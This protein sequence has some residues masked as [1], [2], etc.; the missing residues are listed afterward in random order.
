MAS[1][2]LRTIPFL[3]L[4]LCQL[5]DVSHSLSQTQATLGDS[6][7]EITSSGELHVPLMRREKRTENSV[8]ALA[9]IQAHDAS[10][11]VQS[12]ISSLLAKGGSSATAQGAQTPNITNDI[13]DTSALL[14]LP[15][16][17]VAFYS[18]Y[19]KRFLR[20]RPD[21]GVDASATLETI[22]DLP[23]A[24]GWER[25]TVV[26]ASNGQLA[27]HN[28]AHNRFLRMRADGIVEASLPKGP[29]ELPTDWKFERFAEVQGG[30][31]SLAIFSVANSR[32]VR[33]RPDGIIDASALRLADSLPADWTWERFTVQRVRPAVLRTQTPFSNAS[34]FLKVA[35]E[36]RSTAEEL[37]RSA[38]K[39]RLV[40]AKVLQAKKAQL[41][42]IRRARAII[43]NQTKPQ[44]VNTSNNESKILQDVQDTADEIRAAAAGTK[45]LAEEAAAEQ[46]RQG[47]R[48]IRR[49]IRHR[50][51]NVSKSSRRR[52]LPK[53]TGIQTCEDRNLTESQCKAI[54]CCTYD[55][56][57]KTCFSAV[58]TFMCKSQRTKKRL[59]GVEV[60]EGKNIDAVLCAS[61]PCCRFNYEQLECK[62]RIGTRRC[63]F[64]NPQS[65][66]AAEVM[67]ASD[68]N[69][70]NT[71]QTAGNASAPR[72]PRSPKDA[73]QFR[74]SGGRKQDQKTDLLNPKWTAADQRAVDKAVEAA[75]DSEAEA[76]R[77]GRQQEPPMSAG[78]IAVIVIICIVL[79][80][81]LGGFIWWYLHDRPKEGV[82]PLVE[83]DD[84]TVNLVSDDQ[85]TFETYESPPTDS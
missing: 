8:P 23:G 58:G 32:F 75:T 6:S 44:V 33:M 79:V 13:N 63:P 66:I 83:D 11:A 85:A 35:M 40:E 53:Q 52:K 3:F 21:G 28:A 76:A 73:A 1:Q 18:T 57:N 29:T 49:M 54:S 14:M 80:A 71:S 41:K 47:R 70:S 30:N 26:D 72:R 22:D 25:F 20:M 39:A 17:T 50:M 60:C 69:T 74:A 55:V 67:N 68:S 82:T 61:M 42:Q 38:D 64:P 15:G 16:D 45:L 77:K 24:W 81:A 62:S 10:K 46:V 65:K 19:S 4:L 59:T 56:I 43:I 7:Q 27:F 51:G 5:V 34:D 12:W 31:E 2:Q 37:A 84:E 36:I 48:M 78:L 9:Q